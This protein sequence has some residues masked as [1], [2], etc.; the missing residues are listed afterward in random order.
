MAILPTYEYYLKKNS[1][2]PIE[3]LPFLSRFTMN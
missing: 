2:C 3:I 1:D